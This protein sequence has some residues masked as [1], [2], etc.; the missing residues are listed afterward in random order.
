Q[1]NDQIQQ[2]NLQTK[3]KFPV[4]KQE[5]FPEAADFLRRT[6]LE[7]TI[8]DFVF[9]ISSF[10]P[11]DWDLLNEDNNTDIIITEQPNI[12]NTTDEEQETETGISHEH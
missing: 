4:D 12:T 7:D 1:L 8:S 3:W 11:P 2:R 10:P 6:F 9:S 5:E